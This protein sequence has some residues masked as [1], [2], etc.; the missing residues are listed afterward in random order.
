VVE[1]TEVLRD[2]S[3]WARV[4]REEIAPLGDD[5]LGA[6]ASTADAPDD[7]NGPEWLA[8][9]ATRRYKR[10]AV[11]GPFRRTGGSVASARLGEIA[12]ARLGEVV[13]NA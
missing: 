12:P 11:I 10:A 2:L 5:T 4:H 13:T 7:P 3:A 9:I 6:S 8:V 1:L